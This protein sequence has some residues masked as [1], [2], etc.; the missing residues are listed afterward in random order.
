MNIKPAVVMMVRD[1]AD[2]IDKCIMHWATLGITNMYVCDN[3]SV[4]GAFDKLAWWSRDY[5]INLRLSQDLA[6]DWPGRRVINGL[7]N[8]AIDDGFNFIF[9]A[10][11]DEFLQIPTGVSLEDWLDSLDP[12]GYGVMEYLNIFPDGKKEWHTPQKKAFGYITKDMDISVG[13]H[14]VEG[15][16]PTMDCHGSYYEHYSI[17]SYPQFKR[18]MENYMIAFSKN[19]FDD[20]PHA[21]SFRKWQ[22]HGESFLIQRWKE[23]TQ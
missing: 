4:D 5:N 15:V 2:I 21:E 12:V 13:N 18:K 22:I 6:T 3:G 20:H 8:Q 23:L 14:I 9:P 7:K 10:D 19:G 17:R 11:A 1:E 16:E